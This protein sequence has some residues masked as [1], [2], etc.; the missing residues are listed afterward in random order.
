[1]KKCFVF[2]LSVLLLCTCVPLGVLPT[3]SV[4][5][6]T[7]GTTGDC[8]WTLDDNGHLTISGNGAMDGFAAA[9]VD[10]AWRTTAQWG[11]EITSVTIEDG[12]TTIGG[13]AFRGC[14]SLTSVTIPDSINGVD[15]G[16]FDGCYSL[17]DVYYAGAK[18]QCNDVYI[19]G[20]NDPLL[21]AT[22]HYA[23]KNIS[24]TTGDCTWVWDD[25]GHLTISGY[26]AMENYTIYSSSP[27]PWG[28]FITSVT[29][30]SGVTSIGNSA[31]YRCDSLTSVTIPDSVTSIGE[32]AFASCTALTSITI[33]TSVINIGASAFNSCTSLPSISVSDAN[34]HYSSMDGVLFN[35]EQTSLIQCPGGKS[36]EYIIPNTVTTIEGSAFSGCRSLT[37]V[38]IPDGVTTI[39]RYGFSNCTSLESV[40]IPDSV[41]TIG[42][43]I[44]FRCASLTSVTLP[45]GITTI[46]NHMFYFC[47]A[48][49]SITIPDSV[50]SIGEYAFQ[51]C[52]SLA[53]L[54]IPNG[55]TTVGERAFYQC[56][57]LADVYYAGDEEQKAAISI[58][59]SNDPLLN[60][61][62]HY[63]YVPEPAVT[64]GDANGDG[65]V[66]NRD[67]GM[68]QQY[69]NGWGT[70]VD[71]AALDLNN[72]G[73]VNN[74][75]LGLLQQHLNGWGVELG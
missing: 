24:G 58:S 3:L 12:V 69:L 71:T 39:G 55:I 2:L 73:K 36:G 52:R 23:K 1:M 32:Y 74:R 70:G 8:T 35:K 54:T 56:D 47:D 13:R 65:S 63:N 15:V 14:D 72:D 30:E 60:A 51:S 16:A 64:P 25:T 6:A 5:A 34:A 40:T 22:W 38:I 18:Q 27:T 49:T 68:L 45:N 33:P 29:I 53:S 43:S 42:D 37:S 62:W 17:T 44:F 26:G 19:G 4:S 11:W 59:G 28:S 75:D 21:N 50:T 57:S 10:G 41:T 61:T 9:Y 67:L 7:S 31:F 66:N 46:V 48:L 20:D